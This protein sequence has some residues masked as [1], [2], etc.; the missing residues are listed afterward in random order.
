MACFQILLKIADNKN[1][2]RKFDEYKIFKNALLMTNGKL[3][4]F[5]CT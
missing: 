1:Q 4:F 3:Y 2:I 5:T